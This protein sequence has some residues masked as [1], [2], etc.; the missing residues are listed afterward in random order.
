VVGVEQLSVTLYVAVR[1]TTVVIVIGI[2]RSRI[3]T[4][5]LVHGAAVKEYDDVVVVVEL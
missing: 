3:V 1:V 5:R 4:L 2:D